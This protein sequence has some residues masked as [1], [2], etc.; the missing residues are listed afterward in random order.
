MPAIAA[1]GTD[2]GRLDLI[3]RCENC[4]RLSRNRSAPDDDFNLLLPLTAK[5]A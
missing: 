4:G 3:H 1:E 2:P 5:Q